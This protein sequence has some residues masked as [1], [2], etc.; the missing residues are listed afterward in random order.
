MLNPESI[1]GWQ[2]EWPVEPG[3]YW[4]YGWMWDKEPGKRLPKLSTVEVIQLAATVAHVC[5]GAFM[6]KSENHIG[7][8]LKI[9]MPI[10][11]DL[12]DLLLD[13]EKDNAD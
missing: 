5:N 8:W 1:E 10:P 3:H 7:K 2:N 6:Y 11:L 13:K 12:M 9:S 4:F